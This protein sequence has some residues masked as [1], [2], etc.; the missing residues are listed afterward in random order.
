MK[1]P[2]PI[3]MSL[4]RFAHVFTLRASLMKL[5]DGSFFLSLRSKK[6]NIGIDITLRGVK[7]IGKP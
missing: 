5:Y 1:T 4:S 2:I 7:E 3:Y 6:L